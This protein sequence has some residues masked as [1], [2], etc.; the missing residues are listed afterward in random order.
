MTREESRE[1]LLSWGIP[2]HSLDAVEEH[3]RLY[4]ELDQARA[5]LLEVPTHPSF[6]S[7]RLWAKKHAAALKAASEAR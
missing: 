1:V 5:A 6:L 4:I 2:Q 3:I 7:W